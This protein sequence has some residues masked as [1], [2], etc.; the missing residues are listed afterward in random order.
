MALVQATIETLIKTEFQ[1]QFGAPA[2]PAE[3]DKYAT[4]MAVIIINIL[5]TQM[6]VTTTIPGGS[7]SGVYVD[8]VT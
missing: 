8:A 1:N 2:D 4:A 7:S 5:T 3:M 6:V